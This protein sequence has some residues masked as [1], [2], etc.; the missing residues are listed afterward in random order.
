MDAPGVEAK[1]RQGLGSLQSAAQLI[2][3]E[4]R[5]AVCW[6]LTV[7]VLVALANWMMM[8]AV[9]LTIVWRLWRVFSGRFL[10]KSLQ[11][12]VVCIG[13]GAGRMGRELAH[14]F[15]RMGCKV[16]LLDW[17]GEG[18]YNLERE[19]SNLHGGNRRIITMNI[20][21]TSKDHVFEASE[22]VLQIFGPISIL[23]NVAS[24]KHGYSFSDCPP[25]LFVQGMHVNAMSRY[26]LCL[27]FMDHLVGRNRGCLVQICHQKALMNSFGLIDFTASAAAGKAFI[28]SVDVE[29]K[30]LQRKVR[31][32]TCTVS[33]DHDM[34]HFLENPNPVSK[35]FMPVVS[36][37]QVAN[38]IARAIECGER[39]IYVP[40]SLSLF[41]LLSCFPH[42][43]HDLLMRLTKLNL[44]RSQ[45]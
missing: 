2:Q 13:G 35:S 3:G 15:M 41:N 5:E 9:Y 36:H 22:K 25:D 23:I 29:M 38:R 31:V 14:V 43:V 16:V 21:L 37:A 19:L 1:I 6:I 39:H 4:Y 18:L 17:D 12:E 11:N 28:D 44:Y 24:F 34:K 20:D 42:P 40:F 45:D 27:A 33:V 32:L 26:W 10:S 30:V 7:I 8:Y